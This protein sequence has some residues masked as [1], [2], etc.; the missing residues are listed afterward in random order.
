MKKELKQLFL[1]KSNTIRNFVSII[2]CIS[3]IFALILGPSS[4]SSIPISKDHIDNEILRLGL[5][6]LLESYDLAGSA[7]KPHDLAGSADK[8]Q[9]LPIITQN[10]GFSSVSL[11]N[12]K[13][14]LRDDDDPPK[15]DS[16]FIEILMQTLD[17]IFDKV[18]FFITF[19]NLAFLQI[20]YPKWQPDQNLK[21][22]DKQAYSKIYTP[23]EYMYAVPSFSS[24]RAYFYSVE[25]AFEVCGTIA[26]F[27]YS[28]S[29]LF[30][31]TPAYIERF[32]N[33]RFDFI[34]KF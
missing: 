16:V 10:H 23:S 17:Y 31:S 30:C 7:E 2:L 11:T 27:N 19:N 6:E 5:T 12:E 8:P 28:C 14:I 25:D 22:G 3:L 13:N 4:C 26:L 1:S 15:Y 34:V 18:K 33:R 29:G 9:N 21:Y 20:L 24:D 32:Y